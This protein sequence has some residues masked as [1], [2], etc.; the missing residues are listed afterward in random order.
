VRPARTQTGAILNLPWERRQ[1]EAVITPELTGVKQMT[2][3]M[4]LEQTVQ[5][6]TQQ[7]P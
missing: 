7:N 3:A 1:R 4:L 6:A 2:I 5:A